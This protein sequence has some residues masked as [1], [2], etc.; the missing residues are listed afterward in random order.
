[1]KLN[2]KGKVLYPFFDGSFWSLIDGLSPILYHWAVPP[3]SV[4]TLE[5]IIGSRDYIIVS[6]TEKLCIT[7]S[8]KLLERRFCLCSKLLKFFFLTEEPKA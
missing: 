2:T 4:T 8:Q 1:M 5:K 6:V 3:C 7:A